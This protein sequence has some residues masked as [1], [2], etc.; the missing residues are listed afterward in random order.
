MSPD[1]PCGC[2]TRCDLARS[3]L[4]RVEWLAGHLGDVSFAAQVQQLKR[5]LACGHGLLCASPADNDFL[6]VITLVEAALAS[7]SSDQYTP[8]VLD[9]L[10]WAFAAGTREGSFTFADY[11]AVRRDFAAASIVTLKADR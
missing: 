3:L 1:D 11:D 8:E 2:R 4:A 10:R 6:S 5:D 9:A 7:L